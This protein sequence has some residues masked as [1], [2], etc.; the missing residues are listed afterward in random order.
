M[1]NLKDSEDQCML[2]PDGQKARIVDVEEGYVLLRHIEGSR[3]GEV[4]VCHV[5]KL[6]PANEQAHI[7]DERDSVSSL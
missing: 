4:A 3:A 7:N 5:S 2:L 6:E 1:N